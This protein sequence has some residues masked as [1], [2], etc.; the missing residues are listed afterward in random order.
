MAVRNKIK[1][2]SSLLQIKRDR[3]KAEPELSLQDSEKDKKI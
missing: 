2:L 1:K 3:L